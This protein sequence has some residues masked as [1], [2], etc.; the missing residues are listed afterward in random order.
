MGKCTIIIILLLGSKF[1][2]AQQNLL[3]FKKGKKI[4]SRFWVGA[5][6]SF[7][8]KNGEWERG[9]I[10]K[11]TSDSIYIQPSMVAYY[12]MGRDT[13]TFNTRGFLI[14]DIFAMPKSG[15][16]IDY[17]DGRFQ[18]S[19]A[20]G[21]VH[22]YWI[23]SGYLFRLGAATYLG[24]ALANGLIDKSNRITANEVAF[25]T[26]VFGLGVLLKCL[27]KPYWRIGRRYHFDSL[28]LLPQTHIP[29]Q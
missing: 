14:A 9:L 23:K 20:G 12:L 13:F 4:I 3:E 24:V 11:I 17:K 18:I 28:S 26:A 1:S 10:K 15:I 19:R 25:S 5:E 2:S 6:I 16:L 27:Y 8:E 29:S 22:F 21:H 7:L